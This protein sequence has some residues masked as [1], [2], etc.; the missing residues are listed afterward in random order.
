MDDL[1]HEFLIESYENLDRLDQDFV[2]LETGPDAEVVGR[3]FRTIHTLK[4][5][6]GFLGLG[7]LESLSHAG[8]NL[9]MWLRETGEAP[10]REM[11]SALLSAADAS[12]VMLGRLEVDGTDGTDDHAELIATLNRLQR[13][14][15]AGG[16]AAQPETVAEAAPQP[17][18][19]PEPEPEPAPMSVSTPVAPP[20]AVAP[21]SSAA[22]SGDGEHPKAAG[23]GGSSVADSTIRVDVGL[24]DRLM[25]LVGELVLNRNQILQYSTALADGAFTA[26]LQRLNHLTT[27]LQEGI[28]K[29]RMQ[30]IDSVWAKFPRVVRDLSMVCGKQV[31]IEMEGRETE[32]DRT[33]IEAIKDPM[34][35][36]VRNSVD[37]GIE[38]PEDR[39]RAG[40]HPQGVMS[41]HAYHEGGQVNIELTDDGAGVDVDRVRARAIER[42]LVTPEQA[43]RLSERELVGFIFH[44][45]F[46]T[47]AAVTNVSGRGVGMDVVK[48]NIERIGGVLDVQS[49]M[50]KGTTVKVKIPLTLA[51]VPALVVTSG[52]QRFAIP[53][54]SL[55]EL[56]RLEGA[57]VR[58]SIELVGDA[59]VL[60]LRGRLLPIVYL[61][62]EL[63]VERRQ[64]WRDKTAPP[65]D[66]GPDTDAAAAA[67]V[68]TAI[69]DQRQVVNIVVLQ[70]GDHTFGLVV[71]RINDSQEIVVKPLGKQLKGSGP[72]AGATIMGDG[73]V[74]LILDILALAQTA[75]VISDTA[76]RSGRA[77][78]EATLDQTLDRQTVLVTLV[79]D[80]KRI[81]IPLAQVD[82]LEVFAASALSM[83]GNQP[84]VEYR[85][86]LMPVI[87]VDELLGCYSQDDMPSLINVVVHQCRGRTIGLAV[88]RVLDIVDEHIAVVALTGGGALAGSA[89]IN[90]QVTDILDVESAITTID[91]RFFESTEADDTSTGYDNNTGGDRTNEL[92]GAL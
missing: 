61:N 71:D 24:L 20:V 68:N 63:G 82:R 7:H 30:P 64:T 77:D 5:S 32:L 27:E 69:D 65:H 1:I 4:G 22:A 43:A 38:S 52:D 49:T 46:S 10:T 34:T 8:E 53:Q 2:V 42:G 58:T 60:R 86:Q 76:E 28:M 59:P 85:G 79:G 67:A 13:D 80:G 36:L 91:Y 25:T 81:A 21:T 9:L 44:P 57:Q 55:L 73:R 35:H 47:A 14:A 37:H 51:I 18:P 89:L 74:A 88:R 15:A 41:L 72:Y 92:V 83:A 3:I 70:A 33:I 54:V 26:T 75:H 87:H 56:V 48:T 12:R 45:G 19:E 40:K 50:G 78:N 62:R 90:G 17:T 6:A 11:T 39:V 23:D 16:I 31:R 84:V 66:T 29:T